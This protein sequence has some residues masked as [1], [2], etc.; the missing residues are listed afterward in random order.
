MNERAKIDAVLV[1]YR[2]TPAESESWRTLRAAVRAS[3]ELQEGLRL[4]VYDNSPA[5]S[6]LTADGTS[7]LR[8][9]MPLN[10]RYVRDESNGGLAAAYS[11]ALA[12]ASA[13][14]HGEGGA[15]T[16]ST[17]G[18]ADWLLLLDQ[19]TTLTAEYLREAA[20]LATEL[21]N[22]ET[23]GAIVPKLRS[24]GLVRSP[25]RALGWAQAPLGEKFAGRAQEEVTAYN[26]GALLKVSAMEKLGGFPPGFWLD[27]LDH[28]TFA[29]LRQAGQGVWVM[30]AELQHA[31]A[32]EDPQREMTVER[33]RGVLAAEKRYHERYGSWGSAMAFRLRMLKKAAEYAGWKDKRYARLSLK[34]AMGGHTRGDGASAE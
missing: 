27:Y 8:E 31:M 10:V 7:G 14:K 2:V 23:V 32:W 33:F 28:A 12:E 24:G 26:S 20:W 19:D 25:H 21:A 1:L 34:A 16:G 22:D 18:G 6:G 30:A 5:D 15:K 11:R 3:P 13:R 29:E 4:L 17:D 9:D